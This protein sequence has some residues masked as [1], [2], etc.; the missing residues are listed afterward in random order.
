MIIGL[1]Q[2]S[3]KR[4]GVGVLLAAFSGY[5]C[6]FIYDSS[7]ACSLFIC[8]FILASFFR[9]R[10]KETNSVL[11]ALG[12]IS[13]TAG[14]TLVISQLI[15]DEGTFTFPLRIIILGLIVCA[16][17]ILLLFALTLRLKL[18]CIL[19][20]FAL[21]LFSTVNAY[22]YQFKGNELC[23][24]DFYAIGTALSVVKGY[25]LF[26]KK[27][28]AFCW[29][30]YFLIIFIVTGLP[31]W[32]PQRQGRLCSLLFLVV[33]IVGFWLNGKEVSIVHFGKGSSIN[34]FL[35][36][37]ALQTKEFNVKKPDGYSRNGVEEIAQLYD[38]IDNKESTREPDIIV[39]MDES[40]AKLDVLGKEIETSIEVTPFIDS[41]NSNIT[42]GYCLTSIYGGWTP[43]SE[44]E[45][46]TGNSL[47]FVDGIVYQQY[48]HQ[49]CYSMVSDL[50]R[51]GY[52]CIAMHPYYENGWKRD[53]VW[54]NLL[55]D[56]CMFLDAFPQQDLIR[57]LV[58][59]QEMFDSLIK[60]YEELKGTSER[61][62]FFFGVTMQNHGGYT[63]E[64]YVSSVRVLGL[65]QEYPDVEQYL[66][67]VNETDSAV[68]SLIEYFENQENEVVIVFY[69]DHQ[70]AVDNRF[71]EEIHG[72][73]F[74]TIEEN[75]LK[76]IVP[77]FIWTNYE[78]G[79]EYVD[80]TSLNFLSTYVYNK[81]GLKLP[82][83]NCFLSKLEET[84]PAMNSQGYYS[85]NNKTFRAIQEAETEEKECLD[86]YWMV[87]YNSLFD[88]ENRS[89]I[90]F[91]LEGVD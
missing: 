36:N 46:L 26:P 47:L 41:L 78:S 73:Q 12:L 20:S 19:S 35:L 11:F 45:F 70:P 61:K 10:I 23:L 15:Q 59:D 86:D 88:Y 51:R 31:T 3:F 43:N 30:F 27:L 68:E 66:S 75:E 54:K 83:Y 14:C 72:G 5:L 17:P 7:K 32:K 22:I 52:T 82:G 40:F 39:I 18:S 53:R 2:L 74:E 76:Y 69:G 16:I 91:P 71:L 58:S 42:K 81:A 33:L 6:F 85:D 57:G 25:S 63:Y 87:E 79:Y 49:P 44:Y 64:D 62:L 1:F 60:K 28:I 65:N 13:L 90:L 21:L 4:I 56:E 55:F 48:L 29:L 38:N 80:L 9:I 84:I 67:L 77:F 89:Q 37:F 50:K 34:G 8:A 24:A